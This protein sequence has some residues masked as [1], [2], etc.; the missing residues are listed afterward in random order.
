MVFAELAGRI[1][2]RLERG[3]DGAGFRRQTR[4]RARLA[5][6]GHAGADGQFAGDEIRATRRAARFGVIV[7]EQH[8]V[9]GHLVEVGRRAGHHAAAVSADIPHTNV[10]AHD[11][12]DVGFFI[13]GV[14]GNGGAHQRR[15]GREHGQTL[16]EQI[17]FHRRI[18]FL[19]GCCLEPR[20]NKNT[21]AL[22]D[23]K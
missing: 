9:L 3:G 18:Y 16:D 21:E 17:T 14:C 22:E 15:R 6:R 7:G 20:D 12:Q 5:D 13:R 11:E 8:A 2:L 1:A 23:A 10:I 19:F 4:G